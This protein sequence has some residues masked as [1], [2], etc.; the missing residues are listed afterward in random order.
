MASTDS[1]RSFCLIL[2]AKAAADPLL[3]ER[4]GQLRDRG[5][6]VEI[7]ATWEGGDAT[8]YAMEAVDREIDTVVAAGG[9]GTI[10][11]VINGLLS[12]SQASRS[13]FGVLPYGTANDFARSA[14]IPFQDPLAALSMLVDAQPVPVDVGRVN[15]TFFLNVAS[16]GFGAQI[17]HETPPEMKNALGGFSY[18]LTGVANASSIAPHPVAIRGED[19]QWSGKLLGIA[20][21]NGRLA[22]GGF[23]VTP[24]A[25]VDDGLL[26]L[27]IIPDV[28]WSELLATVHEFLHMEAE[29]HRIEHLIRSRGQW[30]EIEAE[31]GLHV[32][33]D[34]QPLSGQHFR[35]DILPA[36]LQVHLPAQSSLLATAATSG[37]TSA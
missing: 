11:E 14:D 17:T 2:N 24:Q 3:R 31:A 32:N 13:A 6:H 23:G 7:R 33:V 34:G 25:L 5:H 10:N 9:D 15:E 29:N 36:A 22:G 26:D 21:G 20:V 28:P 19:F 35:V 1:R 12:D 18:F 8:R 30:F 37:Q 16:G 27:T 4:I